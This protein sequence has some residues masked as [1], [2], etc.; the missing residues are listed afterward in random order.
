MSNQKHL[1]L[2]S[3]ALMVKSG[4]H[5]I[6]ADLTTLVSLSRLVCDHPKPDT[7]DDRRER[8]A[9]LATN[10]KRS[11]AVS[12]AVRTGSGGR[13]ILESAGAAR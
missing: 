1:A 9:S 8:C 4:V 10:E 13:A 5:P 3:A 12:G 6:L 11:G 7:T 2:P